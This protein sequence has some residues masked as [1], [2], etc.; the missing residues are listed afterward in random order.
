MQKNF[1]KAA[2]SRSVNVIPTKQFGGSS[3]HRCYIWLTYVRNRA[4]DSTIRQK[5]KNNL[6]PARDEK[7]LEQTEGPACSVSRTGQTDGRTD[8]EAAG[9]PP[10]ETFVLNDATHQL[11]E[12][13]SAGNLSGNA[14]V[15]V[16]F[17]LRGGGAARSSVGFPVFG[18]ERRSTVCG[19]TV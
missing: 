1:P 7:L 3:S 16:S 10:T 14:H 18:A 6:Q 2:F 9:A 8:R 5:A 19:N 15:K 4:C 13:E 12:L 17:G 11:T